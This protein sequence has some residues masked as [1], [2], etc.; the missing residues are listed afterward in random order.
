[1]TMSRYYTPSDANIDKTGIPPDLEVKSPKLTDAQVRQVEDLIVSG[2]LKDWAET[3]Q[4]ASKADIGAFVKSLALKDFGGYDYLVERMV[5]DEINRK[6]IAPVY[7]L[8][9]DETLK[10]ALSLFGQGKDLP[11][12]ISSAKTVRQYQ[13]EV[14]AS[15][16]P[17][18]GTTAQAKQPPAKGGSGLPSPELA[19]PK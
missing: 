18:N 11:S 13:D 12:L 15:K 3:H 14:A 1:M 19:P 8:D 6:S 10:T 2:K 17:E 5:K 16:P 4:S 9:Y 7:D